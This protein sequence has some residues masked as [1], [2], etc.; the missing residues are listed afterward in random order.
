MGMAQ[1]IG[2]DLNDSLV[3]TDFADR[4]SGLA[5]D[6]EI[7]GLRG[8][9][10]L[11]GGSGND[12]ISSGDAMMGQ[13]RNMLYGGVGD[14]LLWGGQ[15]DDTLIG[16]A[17]DDTIWGSATTPDRGIDHI[18]GGNGND[19]MT[20][21]G[22]SATAIG[23]EGYDYF[24]V[25]SGGNLIDGTEAGNWID[26]V[27][28]LN[29]SR[30]VVVN[31]ATGTAV[32]Y[33]YGGAVGH[34]TLTDIEVVYGSYG[35]D[36]LIGGNPLN[37]AFEGFKGGDGADTINGGSGHDVLFADHSWPQVGVT[38]D[39][40]GNFA[41]DIFGNRDVLFGIEEVYAT[42]FADNLSGNDADNLFYIYAGDDIVKGR[43]GHDRVSF[44]GTD[45]DGFAGVVVDL[46]AGVS[47]GAGTKSLTGIESATGS[48]L[49]DRLVGSATHNGL[50]GYAGNDRITGRQ[51]D[52]WLTGG[53][54]DDRLTGGAGADGF[55][56]MAGDGRDVIVDFTPGQDHIG[57][58]HPDFSTVAELL[59]LARQVGQN[60]VFTFTDGSEWTLLDV[61][62]SD[63]SAGDFD[64]A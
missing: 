32:T 47:T 7:S 34:D 8:A 26:T 55:G 57:L 63:L 24:S 27:D 59:A 11:Y 28:Y 42:D 17:G 60:T 10:H 13:A 39:L 52:D 53:A 4:I 30:R 33:D 44:L 54:G 16:G 49:N 23:G 5:G 62:V 36:R 3:G 15:G 38:V 9:D 31:L 45:F 6:D 61:Q 50:S 35:N 1:I 43:L 12:T 19:H 40:A 20:L 58:H 18:D 56:F 2:T 51:G 25:A 41:I 64:L 22:A 14:D 37:D 21:G 48:A 29:I 46:Q